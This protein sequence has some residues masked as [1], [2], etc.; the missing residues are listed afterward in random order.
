VN[1]TLGVAW[2]MT[3]LG[4][5]SIL[6]GLYT[7]RRRK[8]WKLPWLQH[9]QRWQPE[10]RRK[11]LFGVFALLIGLPRLAGGSALVVLVFSTVAL[12]PMAGAA[13]L[14]LQARSPRN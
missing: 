10:G 2:L 13:M 9:R 5:A 6:D 14:S 4:A 12:I 11:I 8:A 1:T 3:V 7:L